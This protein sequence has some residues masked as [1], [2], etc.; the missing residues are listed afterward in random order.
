[1]PPGSRVGLLLDLGEGSLTCYLNGRKLGSVIPEGTAG[2]LSGPL[3][4]MCELINEGDAVRI[5]K[6]PAPVG[7]PDNFSHEP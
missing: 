2:A 4:W 1:M 7:F 3:V 5:E 6:V